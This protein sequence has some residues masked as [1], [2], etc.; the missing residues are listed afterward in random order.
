[1]LHD[2]QVGIGGLDEGEPLL[3]VAAIEPVHGEDDGEQQPDAED[4]RDESP[5]VLFQIVDGQIHANLKLAFLPVGRRAAV[6]LSCQARHQ[7]G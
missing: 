4:R 5:S 6:A 7:P 3:K 2:P 1:M